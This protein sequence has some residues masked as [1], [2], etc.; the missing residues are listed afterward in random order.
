M[1]RFY[2]PQG[3]PDLRS[4]NRPSDS[5]VQSLSI[6]DCL[7]PCSGVSAYASKLA[8]RGRSHCRYLQAGCRSRS[9]C[10]YL[11]AGSLGRSRCISQGAESRPPRTSFLKAWCARQNCLAFPCPSSPQ[12]YNR[13][14]LQ[15][16]AEQDLMRGNPVGP[17]VA[18]VNCPRCRRQ[19]GRGPEAHGGGIWWAAARAEGSSARWS[20]RI[21]VAVRLFTS[22]RQV[23]LIHKIGSRP[24]AK[25]LLIYVRLWSF[26]TTHSRPRAGVT[27]L[28]HDFIN[29]LQRL[30]QHS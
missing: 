26:N 28:C 17:V 2:T 9:H 20:E 25:E 4:L 27:R 15:D 23:Q 11:K 30:L 12:R 3:R 18:Q 1:G 10:R 22:G 6:P 5:L 24:K 14:E 16:L 8:G 13:Q 7:L 19:S 29:A 21:R